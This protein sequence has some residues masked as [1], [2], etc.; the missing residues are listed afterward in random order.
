MTDRERELK[1]ENFRLRSVI[2]SHQKVKAGLLETITNLRAE[3]E[4]LKQDPKNDIPAWAVKILEKLKDQVADFEASFK[5]YYD[6]IRRG[7][8][9]WH[10]DGNPREIDP[11]T[12][13]LVAWMVDRIDKLEDVVAEQR[14]TIVALED[15]ISEVW[16]ER[17]R[18]LEAVV[19][20]AKTI[21]YEHSGKSL[22]VAGFVSKVMMTELDHAITEL[23][24]H[25]AE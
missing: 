11:D 4:V 13:K 21:A 20:L 18:K 3:N 25:D 19:E 16:Q 24:A 7:T 15:A 14:I 22:F 2:T 23:E 5:L 1:N 8:K 10:E 9:K 17:V 12:A 6:A